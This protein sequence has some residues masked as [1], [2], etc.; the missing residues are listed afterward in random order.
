[1]VCCSTQAEFLRDKLKI[2]EPR[3]HL[4]LEHV[5]NR[6][7]SPGPARPEKERRLI[8]GVGLEK[9]DYRTLAQASQDLDVD[10]R[11]SGFSKYA[12]LL[13]KSFPDE[14]PRRP[15][16]ASTLLGWRWIVRK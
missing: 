12:A 7:F 2:P 13:A 16:L 11:I 15:L 10:V 8:V 5:D 1:M 6:F 4:V 14:R 9:R 3:I